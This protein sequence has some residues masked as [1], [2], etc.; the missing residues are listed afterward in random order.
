MVD[1]ST[2]IHTNIDPVPYSKLHIIGE[3]INTTL[4]CTVFSQVSHTS[5]EYIAEE[6]DMPGCLVVRGEIITLSIYIEIDILQYSRQCCSWTTQKYVGRRLLYLRQ[7]KEGTKIDP[8]H[9]KIVALSKLA[10][11]IYL[12]YH[13]R[14]LGLLKSWQL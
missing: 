1:F 3:V 2:C 11:N 9:S 4:H 8:Y 13:V 14:S 12:L 6:G 7:A 5:G 10:P